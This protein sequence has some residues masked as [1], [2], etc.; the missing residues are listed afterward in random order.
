[1]YV[2]YPGRRLGWLGLVAG[3][4]WAGGLATAQESAPPAGASE[5]PLEQLPAGYRERVEFTLAH[6]TLT[7][8]GPVEAFT[9][10]PAQYRYLLDH[11]DRGIEMW[12]R[13]GAKCVD[14]ADRGNGRFAWTDEMGSDVHW[15]TVYRSNR[16]RV[17]YAEGKVKPA[18][19][20]PLVPVQVVVILHY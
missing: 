12:R 2:R 15:D 18:K 11:P 20:L 9:C 17:F 14:I 8:H 1:A 16:L 10:K 4:L 3:L 5:V 19:L 6:P 7:T 13:L